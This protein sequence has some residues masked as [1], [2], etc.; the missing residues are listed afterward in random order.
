MFNPAKIGAIPILSIQVFPQASLVHAVAQHAGIVIVRRMTI[1]PRSG[2]HGV[3]VK[4]Q[5]KRVTEPCRLHRATNRV[6]DLQR[7]VEAMTVAPIPKGNEPSQHTQAEAECGWARTQIPK[8]GRQSSN[9]DCV[10]KSRIGGV[11]K[12]GGV[13]GG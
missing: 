10:T 13:R 9:A 12:I 8:T 11:V 3:V 7:T 4:S 5:K 2:Q 6:S 1:P